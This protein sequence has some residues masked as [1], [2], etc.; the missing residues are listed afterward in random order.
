MESNLDS[1]TSSQPALT[2]PH[3]QT[4]LDQ[5]TSSP[6]ASPPPPR[7][8]VQ[9]DNIYLQ[10]MPFL[11][12][13]NAKSYKVTTPFDI[14]NSSHTLDVVV[15]PF[16][17]GREAIQWLT[18]GGGEKVIGMDTESVNK[19]PVLIQLSVKER[20]VVLRLPASSPPPSSLH[21]CVELENILKDKHILKVGAGLFMV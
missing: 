8:Q 2:D 19:Y 10:P 6:H 15:V 3:L 13:I 1:V 5:G 11:S 7:P 14:Y 20:C 18:K 4:Q 12:S 16:E 17:H 21:L 9:A